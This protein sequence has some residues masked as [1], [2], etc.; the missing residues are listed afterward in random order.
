MRAGAP[1]TWPALALKHLPTVNDEAVEVLVAPAQGDLHG[2]L[3]VAR[4]YGRRAAEAGA[5]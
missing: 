1:P 2:G 5:A 3:Q 4:R